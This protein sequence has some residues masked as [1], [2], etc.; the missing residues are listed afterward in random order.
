MATSQQR[1]KEV[2]QEARDASRGPTDSLDL[3]KRAARLL[4][5][6]RRSLQAELAAYDNER[7]Y[8]EVN[9][10]QLAAEQELAAQNVHRSE[11]RAKHYRELVNERRKLD[12]IKQAEEARRAAVVAMPELKVLAGQ[13]CRADAAAKRPEG[14]PAKIA[15]ADQG[16]R[17]P[18]RGALGRAGQ[19]LS[20]SR[21]ASKTAGMT[22]AIGMLL[23]KQQAELPDL[24]AHR[25]H[26][27]QI[28]S[29]TGQ[30]K[31]KLI[32]LEEQKSSWRISRSRFAR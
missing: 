23:Q 13:E 4:T 30:V 26:L 25:R 5:A 24:R 17:A 31:A 27:R 28:G 32:E 9:S 21:L 19:I 1:L 8:Y 11:Q 3:P 15:G 22:D 10:E 20:G 12:A 14:F 18:P 7:L 29:E 16:A 6:M 2:H